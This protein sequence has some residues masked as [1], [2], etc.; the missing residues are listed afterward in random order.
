MAQKLK[1]KTIKYCF[2]FRRMTYIFSI[3]QDNRSK[4]S[5]QAIVLHSMFNTPQGVGVR[6][7]VSLHSR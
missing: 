1:D 2:S 3:L 6:L 4:E 7:D 5:Q